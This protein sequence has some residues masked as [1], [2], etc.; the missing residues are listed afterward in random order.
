MVVITWIVLLIVGNGVTEIEICM[1][2]IIN[3]KQKEETH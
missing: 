3:L 1:E 2:S